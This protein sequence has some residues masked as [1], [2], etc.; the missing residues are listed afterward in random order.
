MKFARAGVTLGLALGIL[1]AAPTSDAQPP[2]KVQRIG[3]LGMTTPSGH[4]LQLEALRQGLRDL[5]YVEGKNIVI[6]YRWAENRY[7]RLPALAAELARLPV[8]II[9][10]HGT[11]GTLAAKQA[12]TTIPIVMAVSG[13]AVATGLIASLA[14]PGGNVTGTTFFNP[15]IAAKRLDL[16]KEA[17]PRVRRVA[18][19]L[20]PDN[21]NNRPVLL[22]MEPRARALKLELLQIPA[23]GPEEFDSAAAAMTTRRADGLVIIEDGMLIANVRRIAEL[24]VTK[25]FPGI[26]F[27]EFAQAGGLLAYGVNFPDIYRRAA[28]FVDKI[29]KGASAGDIPVEQATTFEVVVNARTAR[30]LGVSLPESIRVRTTRVIE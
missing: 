25:R 8:E 9:V 14:R 5:G 7:E 30:V 26:G 28:V 17:V 13:D 6:E 16:L 3:F 27:T 21:T 19:L 15:E 12:T 10:T 18:V 20:N 11:P 1:V 2:A 24:A 4:A 29:L 22:A 23:R